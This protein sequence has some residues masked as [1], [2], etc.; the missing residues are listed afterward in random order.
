MCHE[1][2]EFFGY[3]KMKSGDETYSCTHQQLVAFGRKFAGDSS[4]LEDASIKRVIG[5]FIVLFENLH[6]LLSKKFFENRV[7]IALSG[8]SQDGL[9]GLLNTNCDL[10]TLRQQIGRMAD[11]ILSS[12]VKDIAYFLGKGTDKSDEVIATYRSLKPCIIGSD[13][14]SGI[15]SMWYP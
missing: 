6:E 12:N 13:A 11:V 9:S 1:Y 5:E 3:L 4:Y 2:R 15:E 7:I 8:K 10:H 14:H